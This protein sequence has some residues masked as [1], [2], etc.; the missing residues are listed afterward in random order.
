MEDFTWEVETSPGGSKVT[1]TGTVQDV[2]AQLSTIN[3]NWKEDFNVT[4]P[5]V[6][7]RALNFPFTSVLCMI[8]L[9]EWGT[10][11]PYAIYDGINYLKGV[12]GRPTLGP[13]PGRCGRV[14]CS[15]NSA[16]YWCNDVSL[17]R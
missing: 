8:R 2:V 5:K 11:N 14:S 17:P 12:P 9:G 6:Q 15:Y 16:I 1:V 7:E 13:G 10:A 3:P 4:E